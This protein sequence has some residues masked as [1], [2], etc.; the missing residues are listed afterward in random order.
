MSARLERDARLN[1]PDWLGFTCVALL[2][3]GLFGWLARRDDFIGN[4]S[5]GAIYL[6]M[7]DVL[8]PWRTAP[9]QLGLSLFQDY[10]FPPLYP[11]VVGLFGGGSSQLFA[12]YM[13]TA[14]TLVAATV[15]IYAWYCRVLPRRIE[16]F[17]LT[18]LFVLT[19]ATLITAMSLQSEPLYIALT[20]SA[21]ALGAGGARPVPVAAAL[22]GLSLLARTVGLGMV[23]AAIVHGYRRTVGTQRMLL[24]GLFI[25]PGVG[26][27]LFRLSLGAEGSY[28]D[29]LMQ[30]GPSDTLARLLE[31]AR[32][33]A[34][35]VPVA[36]TKVFDLQSSSQAGV[37][38]AVIAALSALGW[39]R[40]LW[41]GEFDA[42]YALFYLGIVLFWPFPEHLP[43]FLL[44]LMP[45]F[46]FYAYAVVSDLS[47]HLPWATVAALAK[48]SY[49]V[50][51]ALAM[52]PSSMSIVAQIHAADHSGI[53]KF[54]RSP[55]WYA[56]SSQDQAMRSMQ[57]IERMLESLRGIEEHLPIDACVST[58]AF[59]YVPLYGRRRAL[60][61][62]P[63]T[64]SDAA[65][66][67]GLKRCP[68]VFM[69]AAT[70][71]PQSDYP[72]MY[73]F[74]RIKQRLEVIEVKL[75]DEHANH[76]DVLTMLA[77]VRNHSAVA[78][79]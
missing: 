19:P 4:L 51:V 58:T 73:P 32:I 47:R 11:L 39:L 45:L 55:Q 20:F 12:S 15:A 54:V 78:R 7:A 64:A 53:E 14:M 13:I 22:I 76:G 3:C 1:L 75:W 68:Y 60:P 28:L 72:G 46:V 34:A 62:S 70:Q 38:A 63:G 2:S 52:L 37:T 16:A 29:V 74:A 67:A 33:N 43:R 50:V 9:H 65:F 69:M 27:Q 21:L 59:A 24:L 48:S 26:W 18:L 36:W 5:D 41:F 56:S 49:F 79:E 25:M 6:V 23:L 30:P 31:Y 40:R 42:L 10:A 66:D 44:V 8:S 35:Y 61:V 77:R 57:R 71:W 17:G